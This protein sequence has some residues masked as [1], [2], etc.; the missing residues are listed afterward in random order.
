ML[1]LVPNLGW[2]ERLSARLRRRG[3]PVAASWEEAASGWPVVVGARSAAWSPVARVA[4]VV[5]LDAH[6]EAYR[7]ERAPT[8][9][10]W[11]V[12]AERARRDGAP[13]L[14]VSPCPSVVQIAQSEL[15]P[16]PRAVERIGWP[17]LVVLDRRGSDPREGLLS[18]PF[19]GA[20]LKVLGDGERVVCVLNRTGRARLLACA[21][22]GEIVRCE[23][24]GHA[25][26]QVD[27]LLSCP[28]CGTERP[29]V[30]ANCGSTRLRLL[31]P[32]VARIREELEALLRVEVAEVSGPEPSSGARGALPADDPI[33]R[34]DGRAFVGTEAVLHRVRRAGLVAFLDFDQHLLAPRFGGAEESLALLACAG[35]LV[36]GRGREP[37]RSG[38]GR[39]LVQT[40]L[41]DHEVLRAAVEG[42]PG[43]VASHELAVRRQLSLPPAGALALVSGAAAGTFATALSQLTALEVS[44][45]GEGRWMVRAASTTSLCDALA[46]VPRPA[47][48]LR[49][50]VDPTAL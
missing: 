10:A 5:V 37:S 2:A 14:L 35:R 25:L 34:G 42:N 19:V 1:V 29:V 17:A 27:E 13:C 12:V 31:R 24:C 36:G 23:H 50:E 21:G 26:H 40:R 39:V 28:A 43:I 49:V 16:V 48:R 15:R 6:D 44:D 38:V 33:G 45:L 4:A 3:I 41:P 22:C 32:G 46:T 30:C 18:E 8:S 9:N 7:E 20:A 47:G 11:Q